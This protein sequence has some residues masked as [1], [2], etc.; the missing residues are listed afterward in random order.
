MHE[1]QSIMNITP[2]MSTV[3]GDGLL[4]AA[5][6]HP[7]AYP[8]QTHSIIIATLFILVGTVG[9]IGNCLVLIAVLLSKKLQTATNAFVV[10]LSISDFLT[11]F[12]LPFQASGLFSDRGWL[13]SSD[14]CNFVAVLTI[15]TPTVSVL[16][17]GMIAVNRYTLITKTK[18]TYQQIYRL[19]IIATFVTA[20]WMFPILTI[21]IPQLTNLGDLGYDYFYKICKWD[22]DQSKIPI[23]QTISSVTFLASTGVIVFCYVSIYLYVCKHI[24][25]MKAKRKSQMISLQSINI[26]ENN[27]ASPRQRSPTKSNINGTPSLRQVKITKN[28]CYVVIIFFV[29]VV[30]Y[31]V[32]LLFRVR[33]LAV[34]YFAVLFVLSSNIN[35]ILYAAKHPDFR[36]VFTAML[37]CRYLDIVSPSGCLRT[38]IERTGATPNNKST[39]ES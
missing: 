18:K 39:S 14:M 3:G 10:N 4:T 1:V 2:G 28:L 27:A 16:T 33:H 25:E 5:P 11:C 17:L 8:N 24:S 15:T 37:H 22:V 34:A 20:T 35:P 30:P 21:V 26:E 29:C 12:V 9:M 23:F 36:L 31:S 13:L 38:I 7:S 6:N 19:P 32:L